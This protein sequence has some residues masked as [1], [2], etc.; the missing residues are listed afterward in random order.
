[1]ILKERQART[2]LIDEAEQ[3]GR[4]HSMLTCINY[5]GIV[6]SF[7]SSKKIIIIVYY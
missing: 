7:A 2:F 6:K 3:Y 1:M 5:G 4:P